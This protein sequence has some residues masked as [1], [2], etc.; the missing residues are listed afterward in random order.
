MTTP[1]PAEELA[2]Q[3]QSLQAQ[4]SDLEKNARLTNIRDNIGELQTTIRC[5]SS[6]FIP[7]NQAA[8]RLARIANLRRRKSDKHTMDRINTHEN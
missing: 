7:P 1:N 4:M 5:S 2:S 8:S 3:I 6:K